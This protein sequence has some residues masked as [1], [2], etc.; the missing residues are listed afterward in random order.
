MRL[1]RPSN[2]NLASMEKEI[3]SE[4]I[5]SST[6]FIIGVTG[7]RD[8]DPQ[9]LLH[10]REAVTAFVRLIK[11]RLPDTELQIKVGMAEGA[12]LLVAQTALDSLHMVVGQGRCTY[13]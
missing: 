9:G 12:D 6:P 4:Q 3:R 5:S 10:L 8:L 7:H 1:A 11:E 2:R 13:R